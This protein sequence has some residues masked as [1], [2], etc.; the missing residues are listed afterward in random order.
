MV[1]KMSKLYNKYLELK[2]KNNDIL[3]LFKSGMFYIFLDNDAKLVSE[4]LNLKLTNF[5]DTVYKCGFPINSLTKYTDILEKNSINYK[6]IDGEIVNSKKQYIE[7]QNIQ[8]Y[9]KQ[10]KKMD[11]NK[12]TPLKAFELIS[13]LQNL[14]RRKL[15]MKR[16]G[17]LYE[18]IYKI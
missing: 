3:Y 8:N 14:L 1:I 15:V 17:N 12:I 18:N 4:R 10:I 9:L 16:L 2:S 7:S 5:N 11:I 6:I 13:N